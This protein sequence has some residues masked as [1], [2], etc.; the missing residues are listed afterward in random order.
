M[1]YFQTKYLNLGKF[2]RALKW[3]ILVYFIVIWNILRP[4]G[5]FY[6][7][8]V[9]LWLVWIYFPRFGIKENQATLYTTM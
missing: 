2:W 3:K 5:I 7:H 4:I 8:L 1:V 6:D 9:L